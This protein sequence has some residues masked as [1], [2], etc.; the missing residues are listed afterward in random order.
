[1]IEHGLSMVKMSEP[2]KALEAAVL[3][4]RLL[5]QG[6]PVLRWM[7]SNAVEYRDANDNVKLLKHR[8][9]GRIDGIVA[10]IMAISR[11]TLQIEFKSVYESRGVEVY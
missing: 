11:A 6:N 1:M 7:A 2:T 3:E 4:R 9:A 5:H 8:S 10:L